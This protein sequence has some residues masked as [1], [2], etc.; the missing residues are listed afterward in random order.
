MK[1][2][3][4]ILIFSGDDNW[5]DGTRKLSWVS[6]GVREKLLANGVVIQYETDDAK[7]ADILNKIGE[8]NIK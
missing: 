1:V 4:R 2:W 5:I 7:I 8:Q 6:P 3:A